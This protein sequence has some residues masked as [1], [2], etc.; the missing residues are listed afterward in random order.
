MAD[1]ELRIDT[2]G[3]DRLANLIA[4]A[5]R[6]APVAIARA[7]NAAGGTT[8]SAMI[9]VLIKQ[10]GLA[11]KTIV[12]ALRA[13]RASPGRAT[14]T[15]DAAGGNI[16]LKFFVPRQDGGGVSAELWGAR[17]LFAGTF[18]THAKGNR[19]IHTLGGNVFKR[20]GRSKYPIVTQKSGLFIPQEMVTG[21]TEEA[22]NAV[23]QVKLEE[24]IVHELSAV[25]G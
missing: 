21:A 3:F 19:S 7:V 10:T 15:I 24:R 8:R 16:R 14:Y 1:L 23:S 2:R 9:P 20:A 5:K 6:E 12:R 18:F 4:A 25:L 13:R 11:R 22:F 17:R